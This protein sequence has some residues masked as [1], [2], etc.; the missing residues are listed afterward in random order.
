M[1][2]RRLGLIVPSG[3]GVLEQELPSMKLGGLST[4][5]AR[6]R[7]RTTSPAELAGMLAQVPAAAASLGDAR[8]DVIGFACTTGSLFGGPGYDQQVVAR[9]REAVPDVAATTTATAVV[10][11]LRACGMTRVTLLTPYEEWLDDIE[12][13]FLE[14]HG[15]QVLKVHGLGL[16][17]SR[18]I[19]AVAPAD[20][21]RAAIALDTPRADGMFISCTNLRALPVVEA[22]EQRLGKPVVTSN[23]A[24]LWAMCGLAGVDGRL[25]GYGRL[26]RH[27]SLH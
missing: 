4:H 19:E 22:L 8:V 10:Q 3:N 7:L 27:P 2:Q 17:E 14:A 11:A 6:V 9:I 12:V 24:T 13:A 15:I 23:Q 21:A 5:Y 1:D 16:P 26:F 20:I 18:D 25:R